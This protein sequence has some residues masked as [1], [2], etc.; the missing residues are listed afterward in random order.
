MRWQIPTTTAPPAG[1]VA[2]VSLCSMLRDA[3]PESLDEARR[4]IAKLDRADLIE[5]YRSAY[6]G[7][8]LLVAYLMAV[9]LVERGIAPFCWYERIPAPD[10]ASVT[11]R[12]ILVLGDLAW[13]R[14]QH[15][16][17]HETVRYERGKAMLTGSE[18]T[19]VREAEYAFFDGRRPV[20]RIVAGLSMT[21]RQQWEAAYLRSVP[22]KRRAAAT[23]A[24]SQRVL[25]ALRDN[26][27]KTRRVSFGL[28]EALASAD[29]QHKLWLCARMIKGGSPTEIALRY[30]QMTGVSIPRWIVAK[31]LAKV[32]SVLREQGMTL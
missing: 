30:G 26:L 25:D 16:S 20:W 18:A 12:R 2:Q 5:R 6:T 21:E 14:R 24:M 27:S 23:E 15:A 4:R 32:Q 10:S 8:K 31:Q 22:I 1:A 19:F 29:R 17:H 13:L 11:L 28:A 7:G 3:P 9:E